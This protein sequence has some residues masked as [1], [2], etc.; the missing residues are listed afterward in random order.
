MPLCGPRLDKVNAK[1]R[2]R[3]YGP[4]LVPRWSLTFNNYLL[5]A[6]SHFRNTDLVHAL[7]L[8]PLLPISGEMA[9]VDIFWLLCGTVSPDDS[10]CYLLRVGT[11]ITS[12]I[13]PPDKRSY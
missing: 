13:A 11:S 3:G 10:G 6:P 9:A 1:L 8:T 5:D 12:C 4:A 7:P 2:V